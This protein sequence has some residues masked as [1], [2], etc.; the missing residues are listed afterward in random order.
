M[1]LI[2]PSVKW[3]YIINNLFPSKEVLLEDDD[4]ILQT[5]QRE[6]RQMLNI[7]DSQVCVCNERYEAILTL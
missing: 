4:K 3:N 6:A 1:A 2:L 5:H 7:T